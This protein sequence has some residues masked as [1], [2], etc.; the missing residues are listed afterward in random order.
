MQL[1]LPDDPNYEL[2]KLK[3][4]FGTKFHF[5][6]CYFIIN[7]IKRIDTKIG[8]GTYGSLYKG[9]AILPTGNRQ[10][11]EKHVAIRKC[12]ATPSPERLTLIAIVKTLIHVRYH[13]NIMCLLGLVTKDPTTS[14][15]VFFFLFRVLNIF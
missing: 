5:I 12:I 13:E 8:S 10:E 1:T 6:C 3:L 7:L 14:K 2:E 4:T 15:N 11:S 9:T